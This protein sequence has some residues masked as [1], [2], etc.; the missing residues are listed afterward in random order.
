MK[1]YIGCLVLF[2]RRS[3]ELYGAKQTKIIIAI[4]MH[5]ANGTINT[6]RLAK[7]RLDHMKAR[8]R[9]KCVSKDGPKNSSS[10]LWR[11][12]GGC[13]A[14]HCGVKATSPCLKDKGLG[15]PES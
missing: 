11:I 10:C 4:L 1:L 3:E 7:V 14:N 13:Q 2:N 8:N 6:E 12:S 5:A 9:Y 15:S